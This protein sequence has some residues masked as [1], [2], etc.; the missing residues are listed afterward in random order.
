MRKEEVYPAGF[1]VYDDNGNLIGYECDSCGEGFVYKNEEA[2]RDHPDEICYIPEHA[3]DDI[4]GEYMT[5]EEAKV[6]GETH[7][8]IVEQVL[9]EWGEEYMLTDE[10]AEYMAKDIFGIAEWAYISTYLAEDFE[11]EDCIDY[12]DMCGNVFTQHQIEAV[13]NGMTPKEYANRQLSYGEL[14]ELDAEFDEAFVVDEDCL[15]DESEK[16]LG[17]NARLTY[18]EERRTGLISGPDEFDCDD[19]WRKSIKR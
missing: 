8:T 3:F 19:K 9:D 5:I 14:A 18:I 11:I 13:Q 6:G 10:Q 15:D 12:D 2:F 17:A 1:K 7:K 16:G 4:E